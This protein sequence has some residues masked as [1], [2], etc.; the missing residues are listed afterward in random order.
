MD[1]RKDLSCQL[2]KPT[3]KNLKNLALDSGEIHVHGMRG[4]ED[5]IK[6][7]SLVAM[8]GGDDDYNHNNNNQ[9]VGYIASSHSVVRDKEHKVITMVL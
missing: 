5:F 2:S 6:E 4:S 3:M 1:D 7:L 8:W 9:I